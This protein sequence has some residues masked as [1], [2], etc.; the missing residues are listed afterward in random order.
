MG[1]ASIDRD[2]NIVSDR[3]RSVV[4]FRMIGLSHSEK[5]LWEKR[6]AT[7]PCRWF[8]RETN[9]YVC[10]CDIDSREIAENLWL[11]L[12]GSSIPFEHGMIVSTSTESGR[13]ALRL[14]PFVSEFYRRVGGDVEFSVRC[15]KLMEKEASARKGRC[16][17]NRFSGKA[18]S[19]VAFYMEGLNRAERLIWE[20]RM[21]SIPC[22]WH[23]SQKLKS[24]SCLCGIDGPD[25]VKKLRDI[26]AEDVIQVDYGI[27][28]SMIAS[29]GQ[30][31]LQLEPFVSD[32]YRYIGGMLDFAIRTRK[33]RTGCRLQGRSL[34]RDYRRD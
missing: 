13:G 34:T 9:D 2:V 7:V 20:E 17:T 23:Y 6:L 21:S 10:I 26:L 22:E 33:R 29:H 14:A 24:Y 4:R 31:D 11:M 15:W 5:M 28:V 27:K 25:V 1:M 32:F 3:V 19:T 16:K 12:K 18:E 8:L 30:V